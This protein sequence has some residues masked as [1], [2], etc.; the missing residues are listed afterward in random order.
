MSLAALVGILLTV[1]LNPQKE[2]TEDIN[3]I[4]I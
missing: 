4:K 2:Q 1:I 3:T